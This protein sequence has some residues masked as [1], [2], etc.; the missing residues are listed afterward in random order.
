MVNTFITKHKRALW[1]TA[2]SLSIVFIALKPNA[3][4]DLW[5][6]KDQQGQVLFNNGNYQQASKT[7]TSVHWQAFSSYG[8]EDYEAAA[9]LYS[10]FSNKENLLAQA[11]AL[12]H[13]RHY[14]KARDLYQSILT[15]HPDFIA[16]EKNR[17]IVQAII[18]EV[19]MLSQSQQPEQGESIKELGDEPQIG[20]GA[21]KQEARKQEIEQLSS[22]QL[23]LDPNL[24]DMW[25]RQ[26]QKDPARFLSQKFYF[27][28]EKRKEH[29]GKTNA[30]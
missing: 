26:V 28:Q 12:A 21:K 29:K 15:Q 1:F 11:N 22:E 20:D 6:T 5:L 24:N 4:I 19:N 3:F 27:Q 2:I 14:L 16:A 7:F 17:A 18:D 8:N 9:A 25:L 10:Q 30:Q 13:G 23:L